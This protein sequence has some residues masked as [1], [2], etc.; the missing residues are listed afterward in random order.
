MKRT[1]LTMMLSL[2]LIITSCNE[3]DGV[4]SASNERKDI[5]LSRTEQQ[6]TDRNVTFAFS[7]FSKMNEQETEKPN[8]WCLHSVLPLH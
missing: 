4:S 5:V 6:M 8:W 2:P 3:D 7:F 1:I